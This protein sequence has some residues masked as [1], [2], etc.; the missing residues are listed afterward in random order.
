LRDLGFA[1][2]NDVLGK[3]SVTLSITQFMGILQ[4][5][6]GTDLKRHDFVLTVTD[7][8]DNTTVQTLMLQTGK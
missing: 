7:N 6:S 8:N 5:V 3:Q 2:G 1:V 4:T